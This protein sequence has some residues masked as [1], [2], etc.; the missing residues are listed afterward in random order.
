MRR[1][2]WLR[3]GFLVLTLLFLTMGLAV[4]GLPKAAAKAQTKP[5]SDPIKKEQDTFPER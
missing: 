4:S 1:N 2:V 3:V 5:Y